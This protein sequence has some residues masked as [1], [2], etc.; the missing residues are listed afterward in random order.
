MSKGSATATLH[1]PYNASAGVL[2]TSL[3]IS[4]GAT[5]V[6]LLPSSHVINWNE[7]G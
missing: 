2:G 4:A 6:K 1:S 3:S 7:A 5:S